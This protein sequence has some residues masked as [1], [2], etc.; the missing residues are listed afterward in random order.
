MTARALALRCQNL[1]KDGATLLHALDDTAFSTRRGTTGSVGA[2]FRHCIEFYA[3]FLEGLP[4]GRI[5]YDARPRDG[6]LERDPVAARRRMTELIAEWRALS[7]TDY[8]DPLWVRGD[9]V[10]AAPWCRSSLERELLFLSSHTLHHYA[11][12]SLLLAERGIATP[13]NFG[14]APSTLAQRRASLA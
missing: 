13:P 4:A 10:G 3:A 5:D 12:A 6:E 1:L 7:L 2:Q 8:A 14:V 9:A 11:L